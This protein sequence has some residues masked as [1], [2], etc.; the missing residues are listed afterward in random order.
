[1]MSKSLHGTV[2][3]QPINAKI[4]AKVFW[5]E[6]LGHQSWMSGPRHT[7]ETMEDKHCSSG[8]HE[9]TISY[10]VPEQFTSSLWMLDLS[11]QSAMDKSSHTA[12]IS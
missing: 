10:W 6:E 12:W 4:Y 8:V 2:F 7:I 9:S 3:F 11:N 5:V 1:M